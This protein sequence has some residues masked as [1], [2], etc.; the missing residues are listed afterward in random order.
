M[1]PASPDAILSLNV[2][3][4]IERTLRAL[5]RPYERLLELKGARRLFL[6]GGTI[7]DILLGREPTDFDFAVSGSGLEFASAF[8][9][10]VHGSLVVL[11]EPDDEARVVYY[12]DLTF[13][14]NG[15]GNKRFEDDIRRRDFTANALA[16]EILPDGVGDILDI[17]AGRRDITE[18]LLRPVTPDSLKLDP[19]R[20]LRAIRIALELDFRIDES[21]FDLGRLVTLKNTAPERIGAELLRIMECPGSY[22]YMRKLFD[23]GRL[24]D[25]LPELVPLLADE[26]LR[27]HSLRTYYKIEE[28]VTDDSYFH[29]FDLEWTA[30]FDKWGVSE[31]PAEV[32]GEKSDVGSQKSDTPADTVSQRP[33]VPAS[34]PSTPDSP[35]PTPAPDSSLHSPPSS[36]PYRRA[37]LKLAGLLHDTAKPETRFINVQ[38]ETHFYGHDSLGARA[39]ARI[40]R[41]RL[42]LSRAQT[43]MLSTLVAEH[44]RLHLLATAPDLTDRAVRRFFRDL[45]EDAFGMMILCFADGWATAGRTG[46]LEDTI[47][48]MIDQ[49][50]AEAAKLKVKRFVTGNELIALG[51][52]PGPVFKVILQELEDL[53]LEGV[54]SSTEQGLD[55]LKAHLPGLLAGKPE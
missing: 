13:D 40:G 5:G 50:R 15:F 34:A 3:E 43:A 30:Y 25:I 18:R 27:E 22:T 14:F 44:M 17:V 35:L 31:A 39:A 32:G 38:G 48:R 29:R 28:I 1:T 54:F 9:R 52:K 24:Q 11:S 2:Q 36:L 26:D 42:R 7:R 49:R 41:D 37:L 20:L 19:L 6:V 51:L 4:V 46:H 33:H 53:Q 45:G 10:K 55:Y 47:A 12:R 16:V 21:V 8:A 23:L